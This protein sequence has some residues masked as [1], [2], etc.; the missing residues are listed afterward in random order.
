MESLK[1]DTRPR[2]VRPKDN[3][4]LADKTSPNNIQDLFLNSLRR[5]RAMVTI[6]MMGGLT[7]TGRIRSFDKYALVLETSSQE[8]LIF[9]HAISTVAEAKSVRPAS[10]SV[11]PHPEA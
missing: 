7:L 4:P 5:E 9:K 6:F 11:P 1:K 2:D 10:P 3:K 8:Q